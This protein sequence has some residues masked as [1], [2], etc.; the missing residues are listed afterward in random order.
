MTK[1]F[2]KLF[3][4][5]KPFW[6]M[7]LGSVLFAIPLAGIKAYQASLIKDIFDHLSNRSS[8]SLIVM[9]LIILVVSAAVNFPVRFFHFYWIR[10]V[11]DRATCLVRDQIF[12]KLQRLPMSYY[13]KS[14]QGNLISNMLNDTSVFSGGFR[15]IVDLV[16]EPI[17]ALALIGVAFY[18]DWQITLVM[19]ISIPL[20]IIVFVWSGKR[21]R[22][23]QHHVQEEM[24]DMTHAISEGVA[25]Q[26]I[27][28]AFNLQNYVFKR[29]QFVQDR[30]FNA[31][32]RT[33]KIEELAH[34]MVEFIG[35]LILF[36]TILFAQ[37]RII[38]GAVS[39]GDVLSLL[40]ALVLAQ[41]PIRKYSQANVKL[42]QAWAASDRIF[43]LLSLPEEV[44]HG[45]IEK[46]SFDKKIEINN[47]TFSYGENDVLKNFSF[48]ISKG[49]KVALVGL[50]GSGKSTLI[51]ILLGLYPVKDGEIL[52]DGIKV[53]DIKIKNLRSIFGLVSQDIFLFH[54]TIKE[55]LVFGKMYSD[56]DINK[57]LEIAYANN[58]IEK[59]PQKIET[60]IGDRGTRLSGGQQQRITIARAFLQNPDILLFDE[61]TS[62]LD[63]ESEKV[64]QKALES[65]AKDKTVIA[66][67]HRLS[68]I[69]DYDRIYVLNEGRLVEKGNHKELMNRNGEYAKLYE[70]SKK[71]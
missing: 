9:P 48:E 46:N 33:T 67:A 38:S 58:F 21:V 6:K 30:F 16:R 64:V 32:M 31:Q 28:K 50:S 26:K 11:V 62:A 65:V 71:N 7:G 37:Y 29:F 17:T 51:N 44:D 61:A 5:V 68:T 35:V 24:S 4:Y 66:V 15:C 56:H 22:N 10:F 49:E 39:A 55:N 34:P 53:Q 59:L 47:L 20:F 12:E 19:I 42:G 3:P 25:G 18:R 63:N 60:I 1:I 2:K 54:D 69:Q 8:I 43:S 57:A 45:S 52:I 40:T 13:S 70:L 41:D 36:G 14:K 23:N 27:A